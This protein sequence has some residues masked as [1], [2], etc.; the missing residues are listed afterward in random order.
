[1]KE[2]IHG[3]RGSSSGAEKRGDGEKFRRDCQ[4]DLGSPDRAGVRERDQGR[5][6]GV[7][8]LDWLARL[9]QC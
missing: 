2:K 5:L 9:G 6:P 4:Q 1:M 3:G 8:L 7:W